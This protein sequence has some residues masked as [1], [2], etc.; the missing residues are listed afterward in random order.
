MG[1]NIIFTYT[2]IHT[3]THT[4]IQ[5]YVYVFIR[6]ITPQGS[7]HAH[8]CQHVRH[9]HTYTHAYIQGENRVMFLLGKLHHKVVSTRVSAR[10]LL[11]D[12]DP[13]CEYIYIH[14]AFFLCVYNMN[15]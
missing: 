3:H 12:Y 15:M 10:E 6:K 14:N 9:T 1:E 4:Y 7:K 11:G 13:H 2:H 8:V 5:G